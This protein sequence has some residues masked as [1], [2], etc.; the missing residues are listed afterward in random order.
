MKT[1]RE[2]QGQGRRHFDLWMCE[3]RCCKRPKNRPQSRI[4]PSRERKEYY[5]SID[6]SSG[7]QSSFL[8]RGSSGSNE[9]EIPCCVSCSGSLREL[10]RRRSA[11]LFAKRYCSL[12]DSLLRSH[13]SVLLFFVVVVYHHIA[14][15]MDT[16]PPVL[17]LQA[18][19]ADDMIDNNFMDAIE[20]VAFH[21]YEKI[22]KPS[23]E[24]IDTPGL[25]IGMLESVQRH[26]SEIVDR[27]NKQPRLRGM[28]I[29]P[30]N[31]D[32]FVNDMLTRNIASLPGVAYVWNYIHARLAGRRALRLYF[33]QQ[34]ASQ[35]LD[36]FIR[37]GLPLVR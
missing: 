16:P 32:H 1:V 3:W 25:G 12:F 14:G 19:W 15:V 35:R 24:M 33:V 31:F 28:F 8:M 11:F 34:S 5:T 17:T 9:Y 2:V 7:T 27:A 22:S 18:E 36:V 29:R 10:R 37:A 30:P 21:F 4:R 20:S 26:L 23:K 13:Q 6:H